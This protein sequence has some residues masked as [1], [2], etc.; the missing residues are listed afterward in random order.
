MTTTPYTLTWKPTKSQ[1]IWTLRRDGYTA[2]VRFVGNRTQWTI[3][4]Q[5]K[6]GA[7]ISIDWPI[8]YDFAGAEISLNLEIARS[9]ATDTKRPALLTFVPY[10]RRKYVESY[11]RRKGYADVRLPRRQ[12]DVFVLGEAGSPVVDEVVAHLGVIAPGTVVA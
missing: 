7:I 10:G 1:K 5:G 9:T 6:V 8:P 12:G 11:L 3:Y 4:R 2:V